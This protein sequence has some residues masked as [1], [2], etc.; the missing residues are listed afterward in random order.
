MIGH[1]L[2]NITHYAVITTDENG[3]IDSWN[4]A[5]NRLLGYDGG[6]IL[7]KHLSLICPEEAER[8][9]SNP[10][11]EAL[12]RGTA[13]Y[14]QWIARKDGKRLY[15]RVVALALWG[16][17]EMQGFLFLVRDNS[18]ERS[19]RQKL[20]EKEHFAA[21]GTAAS[22]LAHEIGNPLNGISASAQLI[23]HFLSRENP[24]IGHAM[25]SVHDLKS[26]IG[27][28]TLLLTEFKKIAGPQKLALAPVN[29]PRLLHQ[30]VGVIEQRD[31]R[32]KI[33]IAIECEP[34]LPLLN[35][36]EDKLRQALLNV[37]N[38]AI[39]AMPHGGRLDIKAYRRDESVGI[40]IID[41]GVGIPANFKVFELFSSTKP[42]GIGLGLF[43]V[44]QIVLAHDG[45]ITYSS[46]PGKGTTFR[47]TIPVNASPDS[48]PNDS[49]EGI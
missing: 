39:E 10:L 11:R 7:G 4:Q 13:R 26:E 47:L 35:G 37:L 27:R 24:P 8:K 22:L 45:D 29:L 25:S 40:D 48:A 19:R 31:S 6:E 49:I 43:V 28:L 12:D 36:D 46:T 17:A 38:N 9:L 1:L 33:E 23:E 21:I 41:T 15:L 3:Y 42:N 30:L 2:R 32:E 16:E 44:Q 34:E 14:Y 5:A 20:Q 18:Q